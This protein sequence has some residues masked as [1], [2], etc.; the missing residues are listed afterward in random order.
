MKGLSAFACAGLALLALLMGAVACTDGDVS[1]PSG[2]L[3]LAEYFDELEGAS[4]DL[5]ERTASLLETL[6]T[7][8]DV[9]ELK[10]AASEYPDVLSDFIEDLDALEAPSEAAAAHQDAID[11]GQ[12]F[13]DL[14]TGVVD[15]AEEA[16]TEAELLEVFGSDELA[17]ASTAFSDTCVALQTIADDNEIDA[18]LGCEDEE[19]SLTLGQYLGRLDELDAAFQARQDARGAGYD[20][21]VVGA[22]ETTELQLFRDLIS[23][24]LLQADEFLM[25]VEQLIPPPEAQDAHLLF[26]RAFRRFRDVVEGLGDAADEAVSLTALEGAFDAGQL[27][28]AAAAVYEACQ[29]LESL[30]VSHSITLNMD[31]G[32]PE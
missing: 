11:A 18:D 10:E 31:C 21:A 19:R 20:A 26:L 14:L 8:S 24:N 30:A 7:S 4:G 5:D 25:S 6:E 32:E 17:V 16:E 9:G 12:A 28:S 1:G 15:E 2:P 22:D 3:T 27:S 23:G 29:V 13:L